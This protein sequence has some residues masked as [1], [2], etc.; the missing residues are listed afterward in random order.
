MRDH[1]TETAT[2]AQRFIEPVRAD[3][4][5][6]WGGKRLQ[7]LSRNTCGRTALFVLKL[8]QHKGSPTDWK[9][10]VPLRFEP[11]STSAHSAFVP[12]AVGKVM[13]GHK[14]ADPSS[15]SQPTGSTIFP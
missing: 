15:T 13:H 10:G 3:W 8:L 6:A 9:S 5:D 7:P 14:L 12:M 11:E 4:H 2:A 1:L